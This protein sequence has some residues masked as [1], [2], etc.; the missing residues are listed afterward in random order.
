MFTCS[1][2]AGNDTITTMNKTLAVCAIASLSLSSAQAGFWDKLGT[3]L[4]A[5]S[6]PTETS[7]SVVKD[8]FDSQLKEINSISEQANTIAEGARTRL[9]SLKAAYAALEATYGVIFPASV[10]NDASIAANE[11]LA[12]FDAKLTEGETLVA[13]LSEK[14]MTMAKTTSE[15]ATL[16]PTNENLVKI[17]EIAQAMFSDFN[18]LKAEDRSIAN[19]VNIALVQI[20]AAK[21][22]AQ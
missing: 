4:N 16:E 2:A 15:S 19:L 1:K 7:K 18:A 11:R 20:A 6:Q 9:Q 8:D 21:Q 5:A 14:A 12:K 3:V 17:Q 22:E 13:K 10:T